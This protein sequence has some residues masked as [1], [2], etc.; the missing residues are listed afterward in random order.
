[1]AGP[2]TY[3]H[4]LQKPIK[5]AGET[6]VLG[7]GFVCEKVAFENSSST[8]A[9]G[10]HLMPGFIGESLSIH[11]RSFIR[12]SNDSYFLYPLGIEE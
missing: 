7:G 9:L 2:E 10:Y 3:Q 4:P 6:C 8:R 12:E 11:P 1:M 5:V